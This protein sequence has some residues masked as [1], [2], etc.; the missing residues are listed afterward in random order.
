MS[1]KEESMVEHL[2]ELRKVLII[3]ILAILVGTI[4]AYSM[5]LNQIMDIIVGPLKSLG[6]ELVFL[7]VTEG[8]FTKLKI[9]I[10]AG[11]IFASPVIL[12]QILRFIFPA[13][14]SNEKKIFLFML[15]VGIGLFVGGIT[16][17]YTF[18][19]ELGL[20]VLLI[21]F[22]EGLTPMIAVSKYVSFVISFLLPFGLIFEIPLVTLF[23]T[24]LGIITPAFLRKKRKYVILIMFVLA[25]VLSPGPDIIA[26]LFLALPMVL[27]YEISIIIS[28]LLY[29][30]KRTE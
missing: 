18:V 30:K 3:S 16:F 2:G 23:L 8:F 10:F 28:A 29:R 20:K 9:A 7:G 26:Q 13:L 4:V 27:L 17:G 21:N 5:Y 12:W 6:K 15:I 19:L 14:Y 1:E 22:S 25:A 24:K 11:V